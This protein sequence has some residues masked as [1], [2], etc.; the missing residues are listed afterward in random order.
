MNLESPS[1]TESLPLVTN[2]P[3]ELLPA[4]AS[5]VAPKPI[6]DL[7]ETP[8]FIA[9]SMNS[10]KT[11]QSALLEA[12]PP[13]IEASDIPEPFHPPVEA[14][15]IHSWDVELN[16]ASVRSQPRGIQYPS[17]LPNWVKKD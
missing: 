12:Q 15:T 9:A 4:V 14:R 16:A 8:T 3:E 13:V 5:E 6:T 2:V 1:I 17:A 10:A 7:I 11:E